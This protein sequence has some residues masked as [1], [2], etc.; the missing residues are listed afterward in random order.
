MPDLTLTQT[1]VENAYSIALE[2]I[3]TGCTRSETKAACM[4]DPRLTLGRIDTI[5]ADA[6]R[7]ARKQGVERDDIDDSWYR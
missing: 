6:L 7:D 2:C 3:A 4:T 1:L 5:L